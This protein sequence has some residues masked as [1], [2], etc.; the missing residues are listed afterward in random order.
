MGAGCSGDRWRVVAERV[1]P[2]VVRLPVAAHDE[3]VKTDRQ[4]YGW[5]RAAA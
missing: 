1:S 3:N 2:V 4:R 5:R